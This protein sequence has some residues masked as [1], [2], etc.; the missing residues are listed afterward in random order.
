[1]HTCLSEVNDLIMTLCIDISGKVNKSIV[2][3]MQTLIT[4]KP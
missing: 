2:M 1:M 4:M 3:T